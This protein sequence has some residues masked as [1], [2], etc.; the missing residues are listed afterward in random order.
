MATKQLFDKV[1]YETSRITTQKYSTSF[2]SAIKML[3]KCFHEP[4][5]NIYGF[6]RF[7]DEIVDTFH[8]YDKKYLLDQ[9]IQDTYQSIEQKISLNPI[10]NSFQKTVHQYKIDHEL[11]ATF[12]KSMYMDLHKSDY[13]DE[14]YKEYIVGSA[15]VVGLMCLK[16]FVEGDTALY[17]SLKPAVMRLGSAFQ[18]INFLRDLCEDCHELNRVYFPNLDIQRFDEHSK[19]EIEQDI[20]ADFRA[21]F[22]GIQKLPKSARF[23]V[24]LA[25][26]YYKSLFNKI[27]HT[28]PERILNTRIR[29]PD[30][31]KVMLLFNSYL[32]HNLNLL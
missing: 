11:I 27:I 4:I 30:S 6:V 29:I 19:K 16:V 24:Y 28:K 3:N 5:Y 9:F 18:K 12:L 25:Y 8:E 22:E 1:S 23:G 31:Q 13:T 15:E 14:E 10:L 20:A 7:A 32:R 2:S 26:I 21:G 17:E